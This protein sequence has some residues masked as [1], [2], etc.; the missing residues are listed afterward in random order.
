MRTTVQHHD[1]GPSGISLSRVLG[2]QSLKLREPPGPQSRPG[3][4]SPFAMSDQLPP[5]DGSFSLCYRAATQAR[6]G[7]PVHTPNQQPRR[8]AVTQRDGVM[9][10]AGQ[11]VIFHVGH[12]CLN[13][14]G[15]F[16]RKQWRLCRRRKPLSARS[17]SVGTRIDFNR[18]DDC[19]AL[20]RCLPNQRV[21]PASEAFG[22]TG[23][24]PPT[25]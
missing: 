11:F 18:L 12:V 23:E 21:P 1:E 24:S 19:V 3:A 16:V 20:K 6:A 10:G 5:Q 2:I 9:R 17:N 14:C 13:L 15:D 25:S 4:P 8:R 22:C 7:W